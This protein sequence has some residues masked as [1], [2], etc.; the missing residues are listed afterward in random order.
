MI[1]GTNSW[2]WQVIYDELQLS[3]RHHKGRC[4]VQ[5]SKKFWMGNG[6]ICRI[7]IACALLALQ[8]LHK[9]SERGAH[10]WLQY[11]PNSTRPL[12]NHHTAHK[13]ECLTIFPSSN[14]TFL[15]VL[16][17]CLTIWDWSFWRNFVYLNPAEKFSYESTCLDCTNDPEKIF[18]K[19]SPFLQNWRRDSDEI[20]Q[21]AKC[22]LFISNRH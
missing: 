21:Q 19:N 15:N 9:I 20:K 2:I 8:F 17:L 13:T 16:I 10:L 11:S 22:F 12:E 7:D 4:K 14:I 5:C 6:F 3:Q 18:L 1:I